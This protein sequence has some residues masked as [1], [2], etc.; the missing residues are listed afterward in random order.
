MYATWCKPCVE[1]SE[2]LKEHNIPHESVDVDS[3]D[4]EGM[5]SKYEIR[6]LPTLLKFDDDDNLN[7]SSDGDGNFDTAGFGDD[8]NLN[9]D[10]SSSGS[11][12]KEEFNDDDNLNE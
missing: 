2:M 7:N 4:G 9:E 5:V 8:D 12:N 1:L 10:S 11:V 3:L 6:A